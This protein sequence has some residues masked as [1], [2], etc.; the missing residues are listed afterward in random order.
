M[1]ATVTGS[2][3]TVGWA[4]REAPPGAFLT[5]ETIIAQATE[6]LNDTPKRGRERARGLKYLLDWLSSFPGDDWQQRW[7]AAGCDQ[8]G[9]SWGQQDINPYRKSLQGSASIAL[10]VLDVVRPSLTWLRTATPPHLFITY[11]SVVEADAFTQLDTWLKTLQLSKTSHMLALNALTLLRIRTG[12]PLLRVTA[13][14]FLQ[15]ESEWKALRGRTRATGVAWKALQAC[16]ALVG[17]PADYRAL[18]RNGRLTVTQ[19]VDA[20]GISDP[21]IRTL[22]IDYLTERSAAVDYTTLESMVRV[23]VR[24]FWSD[25]ERHHPELGTIRLPDDVATAWKQRLRYLPGGRERRDYFTHLTTVR[26][27]YLDL[28][29]WAVTEPERWAA[30]ACPSPV[31]AA[32]TTGLTKQKHRTI[33][34]MHQRTRMLAPWLG[35]LAATAEQERR[36]TA[37]LLEAASRTGEG[38]LLSVG[39]KTYR[40]VFR[41][42]YGDNSRPSVEDLE[43]GSVIR[44]YR[45][46]E[47]AFWSWAVIE[48]LRLTGLRVEELVELTHTSVRRYIPPGGEVTVLLQVAP[49]KSDRE[50]LI[51][52]SPELASVL[53]A[54]I[55]RL[56]G[57]DGTLP[58][59]SRYDQL[60]R[61]WGSKLPH[62]FQIGFGGVPRVLST[63]GARRLLQ[64]T[65]S[66]A[67][68]KDVDG[69]SLK[70]TPHDLRRIFATETVN[71]GLPIHI[72][73]HLLGNISLNTTQGYVAVYPEQ[74]IRNYRTFIDHR[75]STRPA[76][77][78]RD[79]TAEEWT[80]FENHFTLR[81][82]ALG[83]CHRP[84]GTP[85]IHEHACVRCPML[86]IDPGQLPR[87]R[88]IEASTLERIDEA[89]QKTWL[90]EVAALEESLRHIRA[91]QDQA[92]Q[93][94][95]R[96]QAGAELTE[97]DGSSET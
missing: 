86:Q 41:G 43:T 94:R 30:W 24:N 6:R 3:V 11:R 48:V 96:L 29:Q 54:I 79:P 4:L 5:I 14:Q 89:R 75:R 51:P 33:A 35:A 57:P 50:R 66:R 76:H 70:F 73:Q 90:G 39:E 47:R 87:L 95:E 46:E 91:K 71:S 72:A 15:V 49:S 59:I 78:Y 64:D 84:Y 34:R 16:G 31:S 97:N 42:F 55:R 27:F 45:S 44:L 74:V 65:A 63:A 58:L 37:A 88:E 28:A 69:M 56:K 80:E 77:E 9:M 83:T 26:G 32:E 61:R 92:A 85:C 20:H 53:A 17:E 25:V 12:T 82:V 22:F 7:E 2:P 60:E 67:N 62:L 23:L 8:A 38:E 68:L 1:T 40:R 10:I 81:R 13:A 21:A 93:I 36:H 52:A 19:L 18:L